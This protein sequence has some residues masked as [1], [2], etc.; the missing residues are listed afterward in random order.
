MKKFKFEI[1]FT[2]EDLE[3]DEFWEEAI[4]KDGTGIATLLEVLAEAIESTNIMINADRTA[5]SAIKLVK[6]TDE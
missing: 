6:Y 1:E 3:G 5:A 4:E 2:E